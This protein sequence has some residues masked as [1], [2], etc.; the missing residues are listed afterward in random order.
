[1][2]HQ[3]R[4]QAEREETPDTGG[5]NGA[6]PESGP[7]APGAV[8]YIKLGKAGAYERDCIESGVV[9]LGFHFIPHEAGIA[10][11]LDA[12]KTHAGL[13]RSDARSG[14]DD[15]RQV[16]DFYPELRRRVIDHAGDAKTKT[17]LIEK[18]GVSES[19]LQELRDLHMPGFATPIGVRPEGDKATR[20]EPCS[21]QIEDGDIYLPENA[22][23]LDVFL[24][25]LL[26]FPNGRND[27]QVDAFSQLLNWVRGQES[28]RSPAPAG[29]I[30]WTRGPE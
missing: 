2:A 17:L 6:L 14:A 19:L 13:H 18:A 9:R 24:N 21:A 8:R 23:W 15:A 30:V 1:M 10:G 5:P 28:R 20:V 27:D 3:N 22:P 7:I 16:C 4:T 29:G 26:A 25:E 11:D 12:M